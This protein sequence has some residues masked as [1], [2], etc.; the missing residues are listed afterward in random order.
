MKENI[1][2]YFTINKL[3][4]NGDPALHYDRLAIILYIFN[5]FKRTLNKQKLYQPGFT[6][7]IIQYNKDL[8]MQ[9]FDTRGLCNIYAQENQLTDSL[10]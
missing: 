5:Y 7:S 4:Q 3:K 2:I 9:Y 8:K 1:R 6:I 10:L